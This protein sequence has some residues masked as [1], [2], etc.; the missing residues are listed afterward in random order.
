MYIYLLSLSYTHTHTACGIE[1]CVECEPATEGGSGRDECITCLAGTI[2]FDGL[3]FS[4]PLAL[5]ARSGILQEAEEREEIAIQ[6]MR[7]IECK[8]IKYGYRHALCHGNTILTKI[9]T[10]MI[11]CACKW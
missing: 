5:V 6:R 10:T 11:I 3:C 7:Q 9:T 1:Y 4:C 2:H 8:F